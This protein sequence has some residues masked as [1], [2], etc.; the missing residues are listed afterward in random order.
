MKLHKPEKKLN[1]FECMND[2][3]MLFSAEAMLFSSEA[4][5]Y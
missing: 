2:E 3:A 5:L 1:R 4:M